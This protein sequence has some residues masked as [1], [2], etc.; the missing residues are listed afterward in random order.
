MSS[1]NIPCWPQ[2]N[3]PHGSWD[4]LICMLLMALCVSPKLHNSMFPPIKFPSSHDVSWGMF[5]GDPISC[6]QSIQPQNSIFNQVDQHD[7]GDILVW[8]DLVG[9]APHSVF[10]SMDIPLNFWYV[11]ICTS[12]VQHGIPR[13]Q[14]LKLLI[15]CYGIHAES[16]VGIKI[17]DCLQL[18]CHGC[19]LS[20]V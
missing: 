2:T 3:G 19:D 14:W 7:S 8:E 12:T 9:G 11:F 18:V 16:A 5:I 10:H 17:N 6:R 13:M 1:L 20:I 15:C 4:H